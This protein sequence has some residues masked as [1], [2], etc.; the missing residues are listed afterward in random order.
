MSLEIDGNGDSLGSWTSVCLACE[1]FR[2]A[3]PRLLFSRALPLTRTFSF[4][5][6]VQ[7]IAKRER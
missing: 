4:S 2:A 1:Y 6:F 3:A 5:F 7:A